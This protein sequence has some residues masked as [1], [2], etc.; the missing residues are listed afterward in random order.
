ML[1]YNSTVSG[2]C[3][4][5]RLLLAHLGLEYETVE[6]SVVERSNRK[7]LLGELNP[8]LR[9]PTL[10]LD[11]GR[12]LGESNAILWYFGDG[13]DYVPA[14]GYERA[15]VLQWMFFEQY[16]HEPNIAV[17]RFWI[18]YSGT[19][20]RVRGPAPGPDEGR[21]RGARRHGVPPRGALVPRRR[22]LLDRGHRALRVHARRPRGRLRARRLSR[23]SAPGSSGSERSRATLRSTRDADT[24]SLRAEPDRLSPPRE[25][26]DSGRQPALRRRARGR[27]RAADRR[28][29]P[30]ARRRGRGG[31]DPGATS[32]GSG[33]ASTRAP[34]DRASA[35]G[36]R[37]RRRARARSGRR[38]AGRRGRRASGD[39]DA[40]PARR[41][42][43][44][45]AGLGRRRPRARDHAR[46]PRDRTTARTSSSTAASLGR[47][48]ASCRR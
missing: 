20:E 27:S 4:K 12:P 47:S 25:R 38:R 8:G 15:Q 37:D 35:A 11:D 7:E 6:V 44:L 42:R 39:D 45:P 40:A 18:Q 34:S 22:A 21:L 10:V 28:H 46:H 31:G 19:P 5:V 30:V 29:R 48:A 13:T 23:R 24:G 9:V 33:S 1:L 41:V 32:P 14:D 17:A 2:N 36:V 3:Y 26:A 16:S 43:D